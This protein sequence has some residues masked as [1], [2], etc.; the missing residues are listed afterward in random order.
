MR[1]KRRHKQRRKN[2]RFL[3][4]GFI[5]LLAGFCLA[6]ALL[7]ALLPGKADPG[8]QE[9]VKEPCGLLEEYM[10]CIPAEEY[11]RMYDMLDPEASGGISREA[12]QKR[13][14]AIYEG[15]EIQ[16]METEIL[17]WD[18]E[19]SRVRYRMKFDTA[20]GTVSFEN[21]AE[22]V[23]GEEG[24]LLAWKDSLIFPELGPEDKVRVQ[25]TQA[26]RGEILD[27]NGRMLAGPGAAASFGIVPGELGED[28]ESRAEAVETIA[29]LL[30]MDPEEIEK[31]LEAKWVREDYFVPVKTLPRVE[32]VLLMSPDPG[33]ELLREKERQDRL[34]EIPGVRRMEI[35]VR[36]YPLGEAA[37]HLVGYVQNVTAEDLEE[38]AEEGYTAD[39]VIGRSGLEGLYE[40]KLRGRKGCRISIIDAAGEEKAE[41]ANRP[42]EDGQT[43]RLTIDAGL[44][45]ALYQVFREDA[46]CSAA[47]NPC[48][49]E[50][51]ALVSTPSYDTNDF[52]FGMSNETWA[53]L[54][55]DGRRPLLN[56]F[57]Q[58]FCPGSTWKPVLAAVGLET[59][60][61]DPGEDYGNEGLSWQKDTSWGAYHVTTLHAYEPVV[62]ENALMY[63]D[64]IY[65]AKAALRIGAGRLEEELEN[66]G[67][68]EK[69][70][71]EISMTPSQYA[72]GEEIGTEIQLA[73]S[74]YGQGEILV[75]PLHMACLY[76]AFCNEGNVLRP[77]LILE[78]DGER[79]IW[80][81]RAFS[82]ETAV[83]VL[84]GMKQV[85]ND[86]RGTGYR[87]RREDAVLAGKTG[88]AEIKA[89]QNDTDGTELGWFAVFTTEKTAER[90]VL[91]VSMVEDV[92]ERG[93]SGYVLERDKEV[94]DKWFAKVPAS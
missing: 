8:K 71:F 40:E 14:A 34:L 59:G 62:L 22:F 88:T 58:S 55:E 27:R 10:A 4:R 73:D 33:E 74:G 61:I 29:G 57:R 11:G 16:D 76:T 41:L 5:L 53:A 21:Q 89:S 90:P 35:T 25:E 84:E 94:L 15:I 45:E 9:Q 50:V 47:L 65:F 6:G 43:V 52:I 38:H 44:Q 18:P 83:Q 37:A 64:N 66:L 13:N 17:N 68:G 54:N 2:R 28:A 69:L 72:N 1:T 12:F 3:R 49:G 78:P 85:V 42:V 48:T 75:N 60:A 46:G 56:R 91:L 80:I 93:G 77:R 19:E 82:P 39:S 87:A 30:C 32:E 92:K 24:W 23:K 36:T 86:P 51:L 20:A 67:F 7:Y 81:G 31:K 26:V 63:S 70:P 79:E